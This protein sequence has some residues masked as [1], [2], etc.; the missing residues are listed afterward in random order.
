MSWGAQNRSKDAKTPSAGRGM[1][2]NPKPDCCPI[3]PYVN[4]WPETTHWPLRCSAPGD[5]MPPC[6]RADFGPEISCGDTCFIC[7]LDR[8]PARFRVG[9]GGWPKTQFWS[10]MGSFCMIGIHAP[11]R[12]AFE[13]NEPDHLLWG[14]FRWAE[15]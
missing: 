11:R 5:G 15:F 14:C 8:L 1:S 9:R 3:Q 6:G 12:I 7:A 10:T 13:Q 2:E 4:P